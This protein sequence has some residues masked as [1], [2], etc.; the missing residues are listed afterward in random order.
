MPE[1]FPTHS[2]SQSLIVLTLAAANMSL[3]CHDVP[4]GSGQKPD[5]GQAPT[6]GGSEGFGWLAGGEIEAG[7]LRGGRLVAGG[8]A[9]AGEGGFGGKGALAFTPTY[10]DAK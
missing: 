7:G 6:A 8:I 10:E 3:P 5:A 4:T 2:A 1:Q 9:V